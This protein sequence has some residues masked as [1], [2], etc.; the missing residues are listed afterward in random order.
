VKKYDKI[1]EGKASKEWAER[2]ESFE[3]ASTTEILGLIDV[4]SEFV[5]RD[6]LLEWQHGEMMEKLQEQDNIMPAV[7]LLPLAVSLILFIVS[8]QLPPVAPNNPA[9]NRCLSVLILSISLWLTTAIPYFATALVIPVLITVTGVL[10][11]EVNHE[12]V[13]SS[14]DSAKFVLSHLFNHT[15]VTTTPSSLHLTSSVDALAWWLHPLLCLLQMSIR[16][17]GS[18]LDAKEIRPLSSEVFVGSN[19]SRTISVDVDFQS[20]SSDPTLDHAAAPRERS[21]EGIQVP[22]PR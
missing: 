10:K 15:T 20:Y 19:V 3:F 11:D 13:L 5:S 12:T 18:R 14:S 6:K 2:V 4:I 16:A 7:K 8:F 22:P 17:T 1:L 9:A 21:T